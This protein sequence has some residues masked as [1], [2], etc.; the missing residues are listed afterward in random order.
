ML[1]LGSAALSFNAAPALAAVRPAAGVSMMAKSQSLPF[2]EA[3][4]QLDGSMAGDVV[5]LCL[6]ALPCGA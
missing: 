5:R 4:P 1:S 3:P 6:P 2:L